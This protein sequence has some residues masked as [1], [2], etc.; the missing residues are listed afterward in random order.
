VQEFEPGFYP[1]GALASFAA[2]SYTF[3]HFALFS[4]EL[5]REFF[6]SQGHGIFA[7]P[8]G[9][10]HSTSFENTITAVGEV[11]PAELSRKR[12]RRVLF[13][14]RP[15]PHALR[16]MFD[17]GIMALRK[18]VAQDAFAGWE[19][20]GIGTV[21][22]HGQIDL[23]NGAKLSLLPRHDQEAYRRIL[24]DYD[25][26]L[27]LMCSPHPS[28]VPL[29]MCSAGMMTVTNTY[30]NKTAEKLLAISENF[31]PV[32]GT[33]DGVLNGLL[34]AKAGLSNV[35]KRSRAANVNWATRWEQSFHPALLDQLDLFLLAAMEDRD[36]PESH[37]MRAA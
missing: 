8:G 2:Q 14:C 30:A 27:S 5:L 3:P 37:A 18:A 20:H 10:S 6:Q 16:N 36:V 4:T 17:I 33:V 1:Y 26:G 13:Y 11:T 31:V 15:E 7:L 24:K 12:R 35:E 25:I 32:D 28:L 21:A 22:M 23:G 9:E 29:E 19:F 34:A